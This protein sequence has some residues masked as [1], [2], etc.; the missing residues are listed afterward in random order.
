MSKDAAPPEKTAG[1]ELTEEA[2]WRPVLA[3]PSE[4]GRAAPV[5]LLV[6]I[7]FFLQLIVKENNASVRATTQHLA[8]NP[9]F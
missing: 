3:E 1:S 7:F 6:I 8:C 9:R 4:G 5:C 2:S